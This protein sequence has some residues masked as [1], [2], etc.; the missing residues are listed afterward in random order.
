MQPIWNYVQWK[1]NSFS[2]DE[3][4]QSFQWALVC[5]REVSSEYM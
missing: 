2:V 4:V 3:H 5:E 1:K